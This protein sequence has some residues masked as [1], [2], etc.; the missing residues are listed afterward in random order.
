MLLDKCR[1]L[2]K[3]TL[4]PPFPALLFPTL[5]PRDVMAGQKPISFKQKRKFISYLFQIIPSGQTCKEQICNWPKQCQSQIKLTELVKTKSSQRSSVWILLCQK[6]NFRLDQQKRLREIN[7][8]I[9]PR[10][11]GPTPLSLLFNGKIHRDFSRINTIPESGIHV[12]MLVIHS[13]AYENWVYQPVLSIG[14]D[15][16]GSGHPAAE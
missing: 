2:E 13:G 10:N 6:G 1:L 14:V 8:K 16:R 4:Q 3:P 5:F 15:L 7:V 12:G 11:L 9:W